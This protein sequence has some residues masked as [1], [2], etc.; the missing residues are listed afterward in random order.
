MTSIYTHTADHI[1]PSLPEQKGKGSQKKNKTGK[2]HLYN[3]NIIVSQNREN[4]TFK[5]PIIH[6]QYSIHFIFSLFKFKRKQLSFYMWQHLS[7][8][9][10]EDITDETHK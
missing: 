3:L 6:E 2:T 7:Y 10:T 8:F 5:S 9:S 1:S 4:T